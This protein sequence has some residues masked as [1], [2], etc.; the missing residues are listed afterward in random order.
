MSIEPQ[1]LI[2]ILLAL[3]FALIGQIH[4]KMNSS[5][6]AKA[7]N[8]ALKEAKEQFRKEFERINF[9]Y[10]ERVKELVARQDREIDSLRG[11]IIRVTDSVDALRRDVMQGNNT[12]LE[13]LQEVALQLRRS[14]P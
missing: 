14:Q 11:E 12:V 9:E 8:E 2:G 4:S 3:I 13:R 5:L 10:N 7:S 6:E 1:W